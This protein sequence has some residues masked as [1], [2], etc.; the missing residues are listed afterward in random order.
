MGELLANSRALGDSG[1]A[2]LCAKLGAPETEL[3]ASPQKAL[4][5]LTQ[6]IIGVHL[7]GILHTGSVP[8]VP[9]PITGTTE[10]L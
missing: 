1:R 10:A 9:S 8:C 6:K 4:V 2:G 5:L 3:Q 7:H